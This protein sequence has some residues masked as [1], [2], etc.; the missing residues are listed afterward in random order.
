M[1]DRYQVIIVGG[2]PV[3]VALAVD[4]GLRGVSCALV[5]RH[6]APQR[7]PKGQNLQARSLEIFYFLGVEQELRAARIL[8]PGFP[9]GNVT[10]YQNLVSEY[11]YAPRGMESTSR[12][13]FTTNERL[14]QYL[15]EEVLRRKLATLPSV[16]T[17]FGR[18]ARQVEQDDQ[19]VRVT[20]A[21]DGWPYEE[22]VL[23]GEYVVG[24]DGQ[25]SLVREQMGIG[26]D[27]KE[28]DQRMVLAV[29]RSKDLHAGLER[30]TQATTFR[31]LKPELQ[32]IWQFFG[33]ID[34]G[35]GFF[36]HA[37]VPNEA[38]RETFDVLGLL[39]NA[40]GF[41][42]DATFDH[43][44]FWDLRV[45]VARE[46]RKGRAFI[47]GDA[48]HNHP[49]Y[50]GFGLNTGLEDAAN[51]GWKLAA[52]VQGWGGEALLDSY[53]QERHPIF[54]EV[55]METIAGGI[56]K[57]RAFLARYSPAKD[58]AEFEQAWQ[59]LQTSDHW[60]AGYAPHYAGSSVVMGPPDAV[61]SI[62]G[63]HAFTAR[64]G[65]HLT[66]QPLSSGKNVYEALGPGFTLLALGAEDGAVRAFEDAARSL[67]VP[68]T[69]IRD[70]DEGDRQAYE[71]KLVLVRPDQYVA[72]AGSDASAD[73]AGIV[74]TATGRA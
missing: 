48:C 44:G 55:G 32:G 57:D 58:R 19:G 52:A 46:Y 2:G 71:A 7:I 34:V 16:T 18:T 31:V 66:P 74:R 20:I 70:S 9:I 8:P 47:A 26:R 67:G 39:R 4:L 68:L 29:L 12:Y 21:D 50:G 61:C 5:E 22:T 43:V 36:F 41:D 63:T 6:Q 45:L 56:E 65:H 17:M 37:P 51:L 64:A 69:V 42:L 40:A 35:E 30:F 60:H 25:R 49:P 23:E 11:W 1:A 38:T 15:T 62:Y 27:G 33:R 24:C 72:W 10:V 73:A 14:P 59:A 53:H 54:Q 28:Y 3:G 13:F